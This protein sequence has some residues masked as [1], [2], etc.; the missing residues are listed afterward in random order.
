MV[1]K[2]QLAFAMCHRGGERRKRAGCARHRDAELGAGGDGRHH[3]LAHRANIEGHVAFAALKD[4]QLGPQP[5]VCHRQFLQNLQH[6]SQVETG[7]HAERKRLGESLQI[8][9]HKEIGAKLHCV[10]AA[11]RAEMDDAARQRG[12]ARSHQLGERHGGGR[13]DRAHLDKE[14]AGYVR[15][16]EAVLPQNSARTPESPLMIDMTRS[17]TTPSRPTSR[18][19][20]PRPSLKAI[21]W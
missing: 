9:L 12:A 18:S 3:F 16:E 20:L 13:P 8:G 10:T 6:K 4:R 1:S 5:G 15:A 7:A 21:W 19:C 2:V 14:L 17:A 11:G